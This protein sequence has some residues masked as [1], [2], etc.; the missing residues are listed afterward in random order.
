[1][2]GDYLIRQARRE[3]ASLLSALTLRS[4]AHWGYDQEFMEVSKKDLEFR[5]AEFLP[6]F[7]VYVLEVDGREA[8]F[9]SLKPGD[10]KSVEMEH[11]FVEPEFIGKGYRRKWWDYAVWL[12][13]RLGYVEIT[14]ASD[15]FAEQFYLKVGA[16]RIGEKES[17]S[18][19]GRFLPVMRYA[20]T[21]SNL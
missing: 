9:F 6:D 16:V 12:A 21:K 17:N 1:M 10:N 5:P 20:I 14:L 13:N 2:P 15:P 4:K 18:R 7:H 8:G 11:L 3:E 19:A